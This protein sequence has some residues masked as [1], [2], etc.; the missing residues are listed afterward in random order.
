MTTKQRDGFMDVGMVMG[1]LRYITARLT[2][3]GAPSSTAPAS[4]MVTS[5]SSALILSALMILILNYMRFDIS[6][7]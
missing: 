2:S 7:S 6:V 1:D 3:L 4:S 5:F